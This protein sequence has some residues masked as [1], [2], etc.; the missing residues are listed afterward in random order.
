[1]KRMSSAMRESSAFSK[2]V[3]GRLDS[4]GI[5]T[6]QKIDQGSEGTPDHHDAAAWKKSY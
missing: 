5:A 3:A 4:V 6:R 1:M 2:D